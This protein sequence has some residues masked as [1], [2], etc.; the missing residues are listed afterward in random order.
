MRVDP[1]RERVAVDGETVRLPKPVAVVLH[2]PAGLL[3]TKSDPFG[4]STV[5]DIL[6]G[7]PEGIL[8]VGRLDRDTEGLLLLTNDGDLA[9]RLTHPSFEVQR[10]YLVT[11]RGTVTGER[12]RRLARGVMLSDG[13]TAPAK[14]RVLK[15]VRGGVLLE[16]TL[17]EGRNREVRRMCAA[18]ELQVLRLVRVAFGPLH[19]GSLRP[20]KW[21]KVRGPEFQALREFVDLGGKR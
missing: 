5:L 21:R 13:K 3:V 2:K 17:R 9:Y 14:A 15:N 10:R 18:V 8:P 7:A 19:L 11:V 6:D 16:L 20:G 12:I 1:A 4:R